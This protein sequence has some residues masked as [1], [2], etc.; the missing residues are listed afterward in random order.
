MRI[1]SQQIFS[2][3]ISRLQNLNSNLQKTDEQKK[4]E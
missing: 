4:N 2:G 3:G 1:S